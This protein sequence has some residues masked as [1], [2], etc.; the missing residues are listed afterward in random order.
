MSSGRLRA[1]CVRRAAALAALAVTLAFVL[2]PFS[3]GRAGGATSGWVTAWTSP[4]DLALG[5]TYNSTIR[6]IATVP[7]AGTRLALTFSNLW[8]STP[9][10]FGAVTVAEDLSG[11][12]LVAGTLH[13]V[14]FAGRRSVTIPAHGRVTSDPVFLAVHSGE[15][16]AVSIAIAGW[17][18]VSVH[19]CC[20]G[21]TD[22]WATANDG[23]DQ[24]A[25]TSASPFNVSLTGPFLRFLS[26]ITVAGTPARGTVVAFGDSITDGYGYENQG[27]SWVTALQ[28]RLDALPA[29]DQLAVV[30]EGISGNTLTVFPAGTTFA[31]NSGGWPGVTRFATDAL[32]W[33][34]VRAIVVLL[35][36]NDI[37]FGAGGLTGHPIP[38]YG[39][40]ASLEAGYRSL[41]AQA[42]AHQIPI[43]AVTLLP[44]ATSTANQR[45]DVI[46]EYWG[47]GEQAVLDAVNAWLLSG[48]SG[49]THVINAASVMGDVYDGACQPTLPYPAYFNPDHLH[50]NVAGQTALA[51]TIPTTWLGTAAAPH[52]PALTSAIPT[53]G[54]AAAQ[55]A[56]AVL[57]AS[58]PPTTTTTTTTPVTTTTAGP[59]L[60]RRARPYLGG[61]LIVLLVLAAALAL[62][63]RHRVRR[64]HR[65]RQR[66][67]PLDSYPHPEPPRPPR[68]RR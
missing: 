24:T 57:A 40:A 28:Q 32:S 35:G 21:H 60:A 49:F 9:T 7:I 30:N 13:P 4:T 58:V 59:S 41:I 33:P 39:T 22:T 43:D 63:A 25:V 5:G 15:T 53:P 44:R 12:S 68:S 36:I 23:G 26:G 51:N 54:C 56:M 65:A 29:S 34:G 18:T 67:A 46:A 42:R 19:Y 62:V 20:I 47:P 55:R 38:P 10:T 6:D 27:Y 2:A 64:R 45:D 50:P 8:S 11:P 48:H 3:P 66:M 31:A 1:R 16:L 61:A 17:A 52:T 37:W 14:T